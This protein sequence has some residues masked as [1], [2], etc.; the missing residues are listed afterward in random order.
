MIRFACPTCKSVLQ[1]PLVKGGEKTACPT[2]GQRI[3]IPNPVKPAVSNKTVLGSLLP[4]SHSPPILERLEEVPDSE[5]EP[6]Q[7]DNGTRIRPINEG[8]SRPLSILLTLGGW[9]LAVVGAV[10]LIYWLKYDTSVPVH[11]DRFGRFPTG[12]RVHNVGLM[13]DRLIGVIIGSGTIVVGLTLYLIGL[14]VSP[15]GARKWLI[16]CTVPL[17][18]LI[19]GIIIVFSVILYAVTL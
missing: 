17:P 16:A 19:V 2:C 6:C 7:P 12:E 10:T 13:Q 3:L 8:G 4:E 18:I 1:A 15:S 5:S 9:L 11:S 14:F